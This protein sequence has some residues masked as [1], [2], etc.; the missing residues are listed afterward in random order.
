MESLYKLTHYSYQREGINSLKSLKRAIL[1]DAPGVGKTA[2]AIGVIEEAQAFPCLVVCP[3]SLKLNWQDEIHLWTHSKAMLLN[4]VNRYSWHTFIQ[5]NPFGINL[6]VQY[7]IVNYE[8]LGKFFVHSM[9]NSSDV[10][11]NQIEFLPQI[12]LF[13][14]IIIDEFHR[15]KEA[16]TKQAK[17]VKGLSVGK[18]YILGLT[19]T[20]VVNTLTDIVPLLGIINRI[21][22]FGGITT[23]YDR[24]DNNP[25]AVRTQLFSSCMI[26]RLKHD[27]LRDLPDKMRHLVRVKLSNR[28]EYD[29]SVADLKTYLR[30]YKEATDAEIHRKMR[31][32]ALYMVGLLKGIAARGKTQAVTEI[33]QSFIEA[34]EKVILFT[35]LHDTTNELKKM[36]PSLTI[37]GADDIIT[38]NRNVKAFQTDPQ[39]MSIICSIKA[40]GVG[41]TLT[42]SSTVIFNEMP[43]TF[44]DAEQC[45]DRAHRNGQKNAVECLY[46]VADNSIDSW[47]YDLIVAKRN[48]ANQITGDTHQ[49]T[50][51]T[52]SEDQIKDILLN[53]FIQEL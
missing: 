17:L 46:A 49:F 14:S 45:E 20:P 4:N 52:I 9:P 28:K 37:T 13:K 27:V 40:A 24:I 5:S 26:R 3:S 51:T 7:F 42:A 48:I 1:A 44:A 47:L 15:C 30:E 53:K 33:A 22:D 31:I 34:G 11:L 16:T 18:E 10:R 21:T 8:S 32:K 19:G 38:R 43:W 39:C 50:E 6:T 12:N 29:L 23:L 2:Q 36:L 25:D 35:H 41:L